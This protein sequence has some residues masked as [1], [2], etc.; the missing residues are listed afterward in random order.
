MGRWM[1][2]IACS[3][4]LLCGVFASPAPAQDKPAQ[5]KPA[6]DKPALQP[7][8]D[9]PLP[10]KQVRAFPNVRFRRP[11]VLTH[12]G[13]GADRLYVASQLGVIQVFD[14]KPQVEES[15][16]STFLD[17]ENKVMYKDNE[18]EEGLLGFVFHPKFKENGQFF[19]YYTTRDAPHTSVISRFRTVKG[20]P[21]K[22]DPASEEEL[23][24]VPQ[25]FWNHNGGGLAFGPDGCLYISLGDGGFKDDPQ[26]N[27]QNLETLLGSILRIDVDHHDQGRKYAIPEDNPFVGQDKARP[28]IFAYGFRNVWGMSFDSQTGLLWAADVGQDLWEE[29]DI[30]EKGGNYGWKLREA[31]HKFKGGADARPDLIE[32]IWEY[33]HDIGKSITG[34]L[35]YRGKKWPELVG[36]FLYADYVSG[37]VWALKYDEKA[38]KVIANYALQSTGMPII[39]FGA[40]AAGEIYLTDSFGQIWTIGK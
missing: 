17:L 40:D 7:M 2:S 13:D 28:E 8:P 25:P 35:V 4:A 23:M 14:N 30:V 29:I 9:T 38:K 32:P 19:L 16:L 11:I 39:S 31:M 5:D 34:G 36:C 21:T 24:R 15:Q 26:G 10:L 6:P 1:F 12:A 37:K 3:L 22:A 20:D 33:H 18:N 27:G